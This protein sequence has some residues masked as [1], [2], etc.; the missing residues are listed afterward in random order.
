[1]LFSGLG[2]YTVQMGSYQAYAY[3]NGGNIQQWQYDNA[4]T[5]ENPDRNA[6]YPR[7]TNLSQGSSNVQTNSYWNRSGTFVRLKNVQV[8]YTLPS[9]L[10]K[11]INLEKV[12]IFAGGQNLITINDFYK[13]WDPE[14]SQ[15]S[16]DSPNFYPLTAIYTFG[17]NVKL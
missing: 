15:S 9:A 14:N 7:I 10:T 3:Y 5:P 8:G 6:S 13:G 4:W 2:G 12:R 16:G 11:R 17:I 1:M